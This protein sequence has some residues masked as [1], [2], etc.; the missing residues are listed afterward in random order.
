MISA[1]HP[2][3]RPASPF[4]EHQTNPPNRPMPEIAQQTPTP[5]IRQLDISRQ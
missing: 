5:A 4:A 3:L 2:R 1:E